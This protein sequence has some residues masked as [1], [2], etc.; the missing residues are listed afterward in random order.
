MHSEETP[1]ELVAA[2]IR[3][4]AAQ[5]LTLGLAESC[6]GGLVAK[7]LT[8]PA[9]ASAVFLGGV[10]AYANSV[11]EKVLGVR[12]ETLAKYG[13]VSEETAREMASG[14]RRVLDVDLALSITGIAGP[15]GGSPQKPVGTIWI[16]LADG[17]GTRAERFRFDGE[18]SLVRAR[19]AEAALELLWQELEG[20]SD[21]PVR[22]GPPA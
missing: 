21:R 10:V 18:R 3:R 12:A 11:K 4:A 19:A 2:I 14:A 5:S 9:G 13:A 8:D 20:E 22:T 16:G 15:A 7:R 6:T 1:G 17:T